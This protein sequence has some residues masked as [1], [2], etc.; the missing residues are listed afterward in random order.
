MGSRQELARIFEAFTGTDTARTRD[1]G[2]HGMGWPSHGGPSA[3]TAARY[4]PRIPRRPAVIVIL[5]CPGSGDSRRQ[6]QYYGHLDVTMEICNTNKKIAR[7]R[8]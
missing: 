8:R 2:G 3:G 1:T 5:P 4:G 6:N 7:R